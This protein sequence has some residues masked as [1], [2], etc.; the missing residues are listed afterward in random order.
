MIVGVGLVK[1]AVPIMAGSWEVIF[2]MEKNER[3][4]AKRMWWKWRADKYDTE[5][6]DPLLAIVVI[7]KKVDMVA[8]DWP[9]SWDSTVCEE[10]VK[11]LIEEN[12]ELLQSTL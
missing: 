3:D 6:S 4:A 10:G 9:G 11:F 1:V 8:L 5:Q 12:S 2:G 7:T